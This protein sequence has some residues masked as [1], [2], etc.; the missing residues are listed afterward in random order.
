MISLKQIHDTVRE[1][2]HV[3]ADH[4]SEVTSWDLLI[5]H[6]AVTDAISRP[7]RVGQVGQNVGSSSEH[8]HGDAAD[9]FEGDQVGGAM[10]EKTSVVIRPDLETVFF[11]VLSIM[12]E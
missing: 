11:K 8:G 4:E 10:R 6:D 12:E 1:V 3:L 7:S 5:V 9:V 2:G